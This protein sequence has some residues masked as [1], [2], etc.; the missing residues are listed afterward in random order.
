MTRNLVGINGVFGFQQVRNGVVIAEEKFRNTVVDEGVA[1]L[2]DAGFGGVAATD[3]WYIGLI[4]NTGSPV[5]LTT[6]T[7]ASH[8]NWTEIVPTTG[9]TGN[10]QEWNEAATA[11]RVIGTTS[12]SA[13]PILLTATLYGMFICSA[14]TGTSG[15]IWSEGAFAAVQP[16]VNGDTI[17]A[18]YELEMS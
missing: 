16:I 14:A 11:S 6:D 15:V 12:V 9:Y 1:N 8:A 18:T 17:N 2:F 10:R 4:S 13:F 5:L 7:L 3:P